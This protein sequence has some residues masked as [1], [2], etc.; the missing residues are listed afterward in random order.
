MPFPIPTL[1]PMQPMNRRHLVEVVFRALEHS[2]CILR[3]SNMEV[4]RDIVA[5]IWIR[6]IETRITDQV[7]LD[8]EIKLL[9][10]GTIPAYRKSDYGE[11]RRILVL[12]DSQ[13]SLSTNERAVKA[14]QAF[15]AFMQ[16]QE[17][18]VGSKEWVGGEHITSD[19]LIALAEELKTGVVPD[20]NS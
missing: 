17:A 8:R 19:V 7:S 5:A 18:R 2:F 11:H 6:T 14:I 16:L 3:L 9:S 15:A 1:Q 20:E 4:A 10:K 13:P 12:S